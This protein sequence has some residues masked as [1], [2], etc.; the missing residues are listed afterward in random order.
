MLLKAS[1][2]IAFYMGFYLAETV[3]NMCIFFVGNKI[4]VAHKF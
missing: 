4:V 3:V 1:E 2:L